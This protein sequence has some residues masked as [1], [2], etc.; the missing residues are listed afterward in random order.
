MTYSL[1]PEAEQDIADALDFYSK[2]AG[3]LVSRR[4][5][6]E[7]ERVANLLVEHPGLGTTDCAGSK[8]LSV[9]CF[10]V[11]GCVPRDGKLYS[12]CHCSASASQAWLWWHK[13]VGCVNDR[14]LCLQAFH[15]AQQGAEHGRAK[16][17]R[18]LAYR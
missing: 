6:S 3:Q 11:L 17:A 13:A 5:F 14:V 1:H 12:N 2:E 16:N 10:S 7:F 8:S 15:D 18:R 9:A 4:F